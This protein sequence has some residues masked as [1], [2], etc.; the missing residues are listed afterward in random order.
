MLPDMPRVAADLLEAGFDTPATR[1]LAGETQINN[2]AD[3]QPLVSR[4]FS[5][6]GISPLLGE[7]EA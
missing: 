7:Q 3:A 4:M 1:R 5:E 2:S 6:L